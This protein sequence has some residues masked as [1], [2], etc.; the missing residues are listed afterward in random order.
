MSVH[1]PTA[2]NASMDLL[3]SSPL[4]PALAPVT[5]TESRHAHVHR[6]QKASALHSVHPRRRALGGCPGGWWR[7]WLA[8]VACITTGLRGAAH[9]AEDGSPA[10]TL[11]CSS[12]GDHHCSSVWV[13]LLSHVCRRA[14]VWTEA[15]PCSPAPGRLRLARSWVRPP[16]SGCPSPPRC[17]PCL[18]VHRTGALGFVRPAAVMHEQ[19]GLALRTCG[20]VV[21]AR[22]C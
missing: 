1:L 14:C 7:P 12:T 21:K 17:L 13:C 15:R 22:P 5:A 3:R 16:G 10:A 19:R 11:A 9:I 6:V 8:C 20:R 2:C 4:P 18:Q